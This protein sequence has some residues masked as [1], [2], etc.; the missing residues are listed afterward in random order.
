MKHI[1]IKVEGMKCSG[2]ENRIVNTLKNLE[3]VENVSASNEKGTVD[4]T[5]VETMNSNILK[6]KIEN[7]G[8][9]VIGEEV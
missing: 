4:I 9:S 1:I 7:L 8:F 6:E 2:C 5:L 3:G